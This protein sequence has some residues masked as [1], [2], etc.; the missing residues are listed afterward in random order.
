ME[1]WRVG[2]LEGWRG[3]GVEVEGWRDGGLEGWRGGGVEGWRDGVVLAWWR[4]RGKMG[5]GYGMA[6]APAHAP[7]H[8]V[9]PISSAHL[10]F[11]GAWF[12]EQ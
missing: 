2:G 10:V 8:S 1:G 12:T 11:F 5:I 9:W 7:H 4:A 3:G 6:L